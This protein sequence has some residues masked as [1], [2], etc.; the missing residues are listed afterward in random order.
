MRQARRPRFSRQTVLALAISLITISTF[1]QE[2]RSAPEAAKTPAISVFEIPRIIDGQRT[3][4]TLAQI[5]DLAGAEAALNVLIERYPSVAAFHYELAALVLRQGRK[6]E[7]MQSLAR[8]VEAGLP[9]VSLENTPAFDALHGDHAFQELVT[10]AKPQTPSVQVPEADTHVEPTL[11]ENGM[12][13]VSVVNTGWDPRLGMLR[14]LFRFAENGR[15]QTPIGNSDSPNE[16][17]L[18]CLVREG[19]SPP[20]WLV[21]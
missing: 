12:A 10:K 17:R 4:A 1:A 2:P 20:Q 9:R 21:A 5:G 6:D 18:Q 15:Q 14:S 16:A 19:R 7:A 13:L 3:A 8:A 11:V